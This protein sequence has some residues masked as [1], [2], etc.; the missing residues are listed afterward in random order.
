LAKM[1]PRRLA[2]LTI[3]SMLDAGIT[4]SPLSEFRVEAVQR[5]TQWRKSSN[6]ATI[7]RRL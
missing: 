4:K 2:R 3:F 5:T 7:E 1:K 6:Y